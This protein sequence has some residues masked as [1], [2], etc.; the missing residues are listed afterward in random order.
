MPRIYYSKS[1]CI[2]KVNEYLSIRE[3]LLAYSLDVAYI[4]SELCVMDEKFPPKGIW[5]DYYQVYDLRC[6][7]NIDDDED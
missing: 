3:D 4:C 2:Q 6:L 5:V 7:I 1:E